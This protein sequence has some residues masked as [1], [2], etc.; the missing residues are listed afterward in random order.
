MFV[1]NHKL[2]SY[3]WIQYLW[4]H[5]PKLGVSDSEYTFPRNCFCSI[6]PDF[7]QLSKLVHLVKTVLKD[8]RFFIILIVYILLD[9]FLILYVLQ[10]I[11]N[12]GGLLQRL[13]IFKFTYGILIGD[14]DDFVKQQ[15][16]IELVNYM[17]FIFFVLSTFFL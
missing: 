2:M 4:T 7:G 10:L 3:L 6:F 16:T 12:D 8:M 15:E 9:F 1:D 11:E 17:K 13:L 14:Y 5:V